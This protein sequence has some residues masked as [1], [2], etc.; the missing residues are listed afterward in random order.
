M[1]RSHAHRTR[2]SPLAEWLVA[3]AILVVIF[4][5]AAAPA[6]SRAAAPRSF[7]SVRIEAGATLWDLAASHP[8]PGMSTEQV[9]ELIR[10]ANHLEDAAPVAG[11]VVK[12][13]SPASQSNAV[14]SR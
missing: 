13:P 9:V 6:I 3:V 12:L 4:V 5:V 11:D 2:K 8:V 10:S 1:T 7:T 14:C